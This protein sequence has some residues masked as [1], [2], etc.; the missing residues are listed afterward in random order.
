MTR[1]IA[2]LTAMRGL[3]ALWV[4]AFHIDVSLFYRDMGALLP[5]DQT[6]LLS[7]GYL[8]VDFFFILSGFIIAH[9][10]AGSLSVPRYL[11]ARFARIYP[12]HLFCLS[13]VILIAVTYPLFIPGIVDDGSWRV[14]MAWSAIPSNLLLTHAMDQHVY[15][16][17]DIVSW[18]ISAEGWTY[19][20]ALPLLVSLPKL[21]RSGAAT[22]GFL[23][24]G[25]LTLFVLSQPEHL[26]DITYKWGFTR[27]L[28]EFV[29]G[30]CL[31]RCWR[32]DEAAW[33]GK[34]GVLLGLLA[35]IA[36]LFNFRSGDLL[37]VPLHCLLLYGLCQS[38]GMASRLLT[39]P[40]P[41]YLGRISYSL[42]L[43]HGV[44]FSAA[45]FLMPLAKAH[46][47]AP[48]AAERWLYAAGFAG[49]TVALSHL[50]YYKVELPMRTLVKFQKLR[51]TASSARSRSNS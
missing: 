50:T 8:W 41:Q 26:L 46:W 38:K 42:Y 51:V 1:Y 47:G 6:G 15:L 21:S 9:V 5:R 25:L 35:A 16:S 22:V 23:A 12:L 33:L 45:W 30:A 3:A 28:C 40:I 10:Y 39:S 4:M 27:C 18:S 7:K 20:V 32:E 14:F 36:A 43:M 48:S 11:Q 24:F 37:I 49:I 17:W 19:V 13:L 2:P 31:R 44:V 29:I 34:D